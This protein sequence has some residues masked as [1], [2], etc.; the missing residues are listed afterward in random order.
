MKNPGAIKQKEYHREAFLFALLIAFIFFIPWIIMDKGYFLFYGDFNVQQITFYKHCHEM[1]RSGQFFWDFKTDLG[2]NFLG[3]YSFYNTTSPFFLLTLPFPNDWIPYFM[4]PLLILK[5]S[6]ASLFAYMYLRRFVKNKQFALLGALL[7]AF[8]GFSIYNIFFNHFH[9]AI[10]FF[11]LL[12]LSL[13]MFMAE[14]K[15]GFFAFMIFVTATVNYFFFVAMVI[16]VVIY[17][18]LRMLSGVWTLTPSRFLLLAAEIL[19]G[20]SLALITLLPSIHVVMEN[21][22]TSTGIM[23]GWNAFIYYNKQI[24]Y[25]IIQVF[26]FPPDLPA[27]PVFFPDSN[28]KWSSLGAWLPLFGMTGFFTFMQ[29]K[30]NH[31]LKRVI[32]VLAVMSLIPVLNTAFMLFNDAF[33]V[34]WFFMLTLMISLATII[35]LED[36]AADW[37][38]G[39]RWSG[40]I[41]IAMTLVVG[42]WPNTKENGETTRYGLFEK[43]NSWNFTKSRFWITCAIAVL[44]VLVMALLIPLLKKQPRKF[45]RGALIGIVI[46]SIVYPLYFIGGGKTNSYRR[47]EYLIPDFL[48]SYQAFNIGDTD[49]FRVDVFNGIDN[50]AMFWNMPTIQA[51]HSNVPVSIMDYYNFVGVERSVGSRPEPETYGLRGM[52]SVKYLMQSTEED[53]LGNQ[54][55]A[56]GSGDR[57]SWSDAFTGSDGKNA[58][59]EGFKLYTVQNNHLVYEN[60][61]FV[62]YGFTYDYYMDKKTLEGYDEKSRDRIMMKALVLDDD[63]N[64]SDTLTQ[65]YKQYLKPFNGMTQLSGGKTEE[66]AAAGE[67]DYYNSARTAPAVG[68]TADFYVETS[69]DQYVKDCAERKATACASFTPDKTGF[70]AVTKEDH[71]ANLV[72]FSVPFEAGWSAEVDGKEV[73]IV[74][75]NIGVMSVLVPDGEPTV[76][77]NYRTPNL[78]IGIMASGAALLLFAV[79][80]GAHFV[81]KK[82]GRVPQ[83]VPYAE[84][85]DLSQIKTFSETE[86]ELRTAAAEDVAEAAKAASLRK[87]K[88]ALEE[89]LNPPVAPEAPA[90]GESTEGPESS[91]NPENSE[92]PL[93]T[94]P[95]V[96]EP[97]ETGQE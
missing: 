40:I 86:A 8:S 79:Y 77:F 24:F 78:N 23:H 67:N 66:A 31:W 82:R 53:R 95:P 30:K 2:V 19:I 49:T 76:R 54:L 17:W 91:E 33:Y 72:F 92:N 29:T 59:M 57:T 13:E 55:D 48:N 7:Y 39:L 50:A 6:L 65:K 3:S 22:R 16:F 41:T 73:E 93:K 94:E 96:D 38:R 9:E 26:F 36:K 97:G 52:L 68:E 60:E 71:T 35:A 42:L 56:N 43:Q 14:N 75:S 21:P 85:E 20:F 51:F 90:A 83:P 64:K 5:F 1:F 34:R 80:M 44:C 63:V 11:P 4:G 15:R 87:L 32:A 47:K 70:T 61:N 74:K 27:R 62:P 25:N 88:K 45:M 12:L 81:M 46:V 10:V 18:F 58:K 37:S 89:R 69:Y 28:V 84:L